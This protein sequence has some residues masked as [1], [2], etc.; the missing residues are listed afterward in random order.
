MK[1]IA[2]HA[3]FALLALAPAA[4]GCADLQRL[5]SVL[6]DRNITQTARPL[7]PRVT[8]SNLRLSQAPD[9]AMLAAYYCS[10]VAPGFVCGVF[11]RVPTRDEIR[12]VFEV[13]LDFRNENSFPLPVVE[14]LSAFTAYPEATGQ[15][16]LGAVCLT[17]CESGDCP[18]N[19]PDAC[20]SSDRDIRS[21][22]DFGRATANFLLNLASGQE[23]IENL[24]IRTIPPNG[25]T[26]ATIRLQLN[27]D[28]VLSLIRTLGGDTLSQ[29]QQGRTPQFTIPYQFEGSLWVNI[30]HFG[31]LAVSIPTFRGS[32]TLR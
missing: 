19:G 30:E 15:Q 23:R 1:H 24:R 13:D 9:N 31:R 26:R 10:T 28:V 20:R 7:P 25:Q 5:A 11:G 17:L 32:W 3:M 4:S 2:R 14:V 18:Q 29:I 22:E 21:I 12:F 27:P 16:N 6:N 8:V